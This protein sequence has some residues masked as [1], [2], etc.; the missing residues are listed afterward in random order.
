MEVAGRVDSEGNGIKDQR[1]NSTL[2]RA[3]GEKELLIMATRG[4]QFPGQLER[5]DGRPSLA[6]RHSIAQVEEGPVPL[7]PILV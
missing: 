4:S 2:Y 3:Y 1:S 7:S 6:G 5:A